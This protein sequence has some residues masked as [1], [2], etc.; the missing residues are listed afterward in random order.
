MYADDILLIAESEDNLQ[1]MLNVLDKWCKKWRM[2]I[3]MDKMQIIH[4]RPKGIKCSQTKFKLGT[5]EL[6]LVDRY[7]YLGCTVNE[8][9]DPNITYW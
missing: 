5:T 1:C 6:Q 8:Y 7:R 4:F 3:N 2:I 9:L